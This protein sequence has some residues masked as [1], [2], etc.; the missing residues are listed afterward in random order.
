[1]WTLDDTQFLISNYYTLGANKCSEIL[2]KTKGSVRNKASRLG[3]KSS[4]TKANNA[5]D[6][7]S[8]F[9]KTTE[10]ELIGT[11]S[12]S[13]IK[14]LHRHKTCGYEWEA[15]PNNIKGGQ[16][17]PGCGK[18]AKLSDEQYTNRLLKTQFR[19]L[20]P[21][22]G[23]DIKILHKHSTCGHEWQVRPHD[24]LKG[25]NCPKCSKRNYSTVAIDWLNSFNNPNILHAEN[26]GEQSILGFKV[27]GY[28]PS[29]NTVYEFHGDVFHG[30]LD[31]FNEDDTCHPFNKDITAGELWSTTFDKMKLLSSVCTVLYI[32]ERD[33]KNGKTFSRF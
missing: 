9:I 17:C 26:G 15:T 23:S 16:G 32:W 1:M 5:S 3:L 28:D 30:N 31:I 20:S 11:Y 25:Q 27:D 6:E 24:I 13:S 2:G 14:T 22:L 7:Y 33:Y 29:T 12:L 8:E 18:V 21:Y 4:V 19:H 10:F